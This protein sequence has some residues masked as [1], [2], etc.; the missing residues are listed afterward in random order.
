MKFI[1]LSE[2]KNIDILDNVSPNCKA[3]LND[4]DDFYIQILEDGRFY[5]FDGL[6]NLYF[7]NIFEAIESNK[8][9][10]KANL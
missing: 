2:V 1:E 3:I 4:E 8:I 10:K 9:F 6:N 5:I 7:D